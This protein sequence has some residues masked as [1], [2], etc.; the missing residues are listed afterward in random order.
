MAVIVVSNTSNIA[1]SEILTIKD[2]DHVFAKN[3]SMK[4]WIESGEEKEKWSRLTTLVYVTDKTKSEI[5]FL[6]EPLIDFNQTPPT[7]ISNKYHF[8][9]PDPANEIWIEMY[10]TG[11]THQP[12]AVIEQFLVERT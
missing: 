1:R 5:E 7:K 3:E 6:L 9:E 4:A 11:E 8:Q 2:S 12:F 10:Q